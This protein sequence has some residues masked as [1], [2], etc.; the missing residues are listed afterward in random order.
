MTKV[1]G[2]LEET[3]PLDSSALV[4]AER[5]IWEEI[6]G[7]QKTESGLTEG[8]KSGRGTVVNRR[9]RP[10][11]EEMDDDM[12]EEVGDDETESGAKKSKSA[13]RKRKGKG[14]NKSTSC[15]DTG[16]KQMKRVEQGKDEQKD[17]VYDM[18]DYIKMDP[19]ACVQETA[20]GN[21]YIGAHTSISG[22][23][24]FFRVLQTIFLPLAGAC[25]CQLCHCGHVV[26]RTGLV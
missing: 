24:F 10:I 17:A 26:N 6:A 16:T 12:D 11:E 19:G 8:E 23:L 7:M 20:K 22:K 14:E 25:L 5:K 2:H 15:Q 21:K 13:A 1:T 3:P 9:G 4:K 18:N